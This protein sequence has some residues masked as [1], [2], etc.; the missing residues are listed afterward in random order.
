MYKELLPL[1]QNNWNKIGIKV[2]NKIFLK[3]PYNR[4]FP[5]NQL[6]SIIICTKSK[7]CDKHINVI[8]FIF[9]FIELCLWR[10]IMTVEIVVFCVCCP[11][12]IKFKKKF[13]EKFPTFFIFKRKNNIHT[14]IYIDNTLVSTQLVY[15]GCCT[16]GCS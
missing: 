15:C 5:N 6:I 13:N 14:Q 4:L 9:D 11:V 16:G 1:A 3:M 7:N 8:V 12:L 10:F 2:A